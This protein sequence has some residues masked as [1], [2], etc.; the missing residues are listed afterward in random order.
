MDADLD[1]LAMHYV[2]GTPYDDQNHLSWPA[3][4]GSSGPAVNGTR[5]FSYKFHAYDFRKQAMQEKWAARITDAVDTGYVDGAFIDGNRGGWGFGSCNAC[6]PKDSQCRADL[7][8]GLKAAH[9][10]VARAL[11]TMRCTRPRAH[12]HA[13]AHARTHLL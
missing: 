11:G 13:H 2:N 1:G 12:L 8:A 6:P 9:Y 5:T 3:S 7:E 4:G 10:K